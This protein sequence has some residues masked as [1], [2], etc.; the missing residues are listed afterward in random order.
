MTRDIHNLDRSFKAPDE[1]SLLN[2]NGLFAGGSDGKIYLV[3][4]WQRDY[5]WD[6][7]EEVRLLLEDLKQFFDK[8]TQ[9]NYTLGSF[10]THT[11]N[12]QSA[13]VVV[14][15]Q[16]RI[17]TLYLL[18]VA[19]RDTLDKIIGNEYQ[20]GAQVPRGLQNLQTAIR[21]LVQRTSLSGED[22]LP[23]VIEFGNANAVL[24]GLANGEFANLE[25]EQTSQINIMNAYQKCSDFL[26]ETFSSA[27]ELAS[28]A[29][30][31]LEGTFLTENMVKD[32]KQ[33]LD[34]FLKINIRGKQLEGSDYLKNYLFRNLGPG[35]DFETLADTWEKMS[36]NLRTSST[37]RE[38]LKTPEFFLRN[39]ALL[40]KGEKVGGD[41]AVFEFWE[42]RFDSDQNRYIR[43]FLD[44]VQM[45]S[46][47]FAR[48]SSNKFI[49]TNEINAVLDGADYFKGTQYLPVLL[50]AAKLD[51]YAYVSELVNF[52][53]LFYILSQERTQDFESMIP[54]WA[55]KISN[56]PSD[57]SIEEIIA[58]TKLVE[59][60]LIKPT[61]L[62][63]L[64]AKIPGYRY[65]SDTRKIR[66]ILGMVAKSF[67]QEAGYDNV[68]LKT[69][70]K[71]FKSGV[72]FDIDHIYPQSK[73]LTRR[74]EDTKEETLRVE[75]T[76]HSVG[77]LILVNGLQRTY[78]DKDPAD[79]AS[80]YLQDQS[81]FTQCLAP[82]PSD[83]NPGMRSM[84]ID[85]RSKS[86][87]D[88]DNWNDLV[89]DSRAKYIAKVF[90]SLIPSPLLS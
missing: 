3:P 32:M 36:S 14:D 76:Y 49:E 43:E 13:H 41:N 29:R 54:K 23:L 71:G 46:K 84:M 42:N 34:I 35:Y 58:A 15:G 2:V 21:N 89:I 65:G 85:I 27:F 70:L 90:T 12:G 28:F 82:I 83:I 75:S 66:M 77:N 5:S 61:S 33:A 47:N 25:L 24:Q 4:N 44:T 57:A 63:S 38:K 69:F 6:A 26:Q 22:S 50:G 64:E 11:I 37:K 45:Q 80:L 8:Q 67:Q 9:S 53:Y 39:W 30:V 17:V 59:E 20:E 56:L 55:H 1:P 73:I 7:D 51:N 68:T 78:S 40:L 19:L 88:L 62:Q 18:T 79:K 72:G 60:V 81:I 87:A 52:R 10:I 74:T 86:G 31:V 48:I 16:Q